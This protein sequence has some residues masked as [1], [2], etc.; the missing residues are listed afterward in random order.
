MKRLTESSANSNGVYSI[1]QNKWLKVPVRDN[2]PDNV[3]LEPELSEWKERASKCSTIDEINSFIDDIYKLRQGSILEEGEY[4]K[5]NLIFKEIRNAGTLQELKDKKIELEN[6]EMSLSEAYDYKTY[7][8][9]CNYYY[10]PYLSQDDLERIWDEIME[11]YDDVDLANDVVEE[12][13]SGEDEMWQESL[14]REKAETELE[15]EPVEESAEDFV[16]RRDA[17][18]I[19]DYRKRA[20]LEEGAEI[21]EENLDDWA[22]TGTSCYMNYDYNDLKNLLVGGNK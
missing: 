20:N 8:D 10:D 22:L 18:V 1:M 6:D 12:L 21:T 2:I 5:G 14:N 17:D 7:E 9:L 4:G 11:K 19:E 13:E 3:E 15:A 16:A